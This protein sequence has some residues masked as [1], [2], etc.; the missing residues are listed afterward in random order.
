MMILGGRLVILGWALL[1]A[2][3]GYL[4]VAGEIGVIRAA[5]EAGRTLDVSLHV[6]FATLVGVGVAITVGLFLFVGVLNEGS[7]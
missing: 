2:Y 3:V 1:I 7:R 6:I 5:L 4:L